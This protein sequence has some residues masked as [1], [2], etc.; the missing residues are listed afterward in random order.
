MAQDSKFTPPWTESPP[1]RGSFRSILKWGGPTEFKHPNRRLYELMKQVFGMTDDDFRA[2][3][4]TGEM[5]VAVEQPSRFTGETLAELAEIVGDGNVHTDGWSRASVCYGKTMVDVMRLR[6]GTVENPPDAVVDP[7]DASDVRRLVAY[8]NKRRI[9]I[10]A[11]G[12][13][14]GV[15]Q[16]SE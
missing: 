10:T 5:P 15:T 13:G 12:A 16:G 7:R 6:A 1:P 11:F 3:T 2:R 8:C 4:N 9:P 14:S